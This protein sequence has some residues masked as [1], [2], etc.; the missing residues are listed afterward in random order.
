VFGFIIQVGAYTPGGIS[1]AECTGEIDG[2]D[3]VEQ[4]RE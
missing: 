3:E 2:A 1:S 4:R